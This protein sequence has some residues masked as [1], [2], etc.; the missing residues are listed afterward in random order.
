M[1]QILESVEAEG[2]RSIV[3]PIRFELNRPGLNIIEG[4][5]GVGKTT[6][7]ESI[8]W[9]A[10]GQNLKDTNQDA[11][12]SWEEKRPLSWKGTRVMLNF[13]VNDE[14]YTIA[15]HINYKGKTFGLIGGDTLMVWQ[16][17]D[18]HGYEPKQLWNNLNKDSTQERIN[19]LLGANY[20]TF[21]NSILFGQR[22]VRLVTQDNKDKRALLEQLFDVE[23]VNIAKARADEDIITKKNEYQEILNEQSKISY[24]ILMLDNDM[25]K[26]KQV[27]DNW[28]VKHEGDI[29]LINSS[30]K[31]YENSILNEQNKI[32]LLN[33]GVEYDKAK[34]IKVEEKWG[35]LSDKVDAS[36]IR[37]EEIKKQLTAAQA[38]HRLHSSELSGKTRDKLRIEKQIEDNKKALTTLKDKGICPTCHHELLSDEIKSISAGYSIE[39]L[40]NQISVI[41][42]EITEINKLVLKSIDSETKF[43][44][45]Y[46]IWSDGHSILVNNYNSVTQELDS[47]N[48]IAEKVSEKANR[49]A[50]I[51]DSI[52]ADK[53]RIE[54]LILRLKVL[55]AEKPPVVDFSKTEES[56]RAKNKELASLA[57]M[58]VKKEDEIKVVKWWSEKG[59]GSSGIK[60]FIF[61]AML[62]Q[63]NEGTRKYGK[64]L[65]VSLE[66]AIDLTK[67]S[68]PFTTIC[69]LGDKLNKDYKEFSGGEKQR[70]DIVLI[71][72][73]YDLVSINTNFNVL[74][75]D[76]VSEG[77]DEKGENDVF[78]LIRMKAN[79]GK[80][81]YIITHS[82][83]VDRMHANTIQIEEQD[84]TT[85]IVN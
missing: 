34:H 47:L 46:K 16:G 23:W 40:N 7:I 37:G 15:R 55:E 30:I 80:S 64:R 19:Q 13:K 39:D 25:L 52:K 68:K 32:K 66:F 62:S 11:I 26:D 71:F 45:E 54:E 48:E 49:L 24:Q 36:K 51:D 21:V 9:C 2:Y 1:N 81:V 75:M 12:P 5:N 8:V 58:L 63:L 14:H 44:K 53:V 77:L 28:K 41:D 29:T 42:K 84:L 33:E 35:N 67:A 83:V 20:K 59:F 85:K 74:I 69:S 22:M 3:H 78:D 18:D 57:D 27:A 82:S 17:D 65:G 6:L 60:A 10:Y 50:E 73:M 31:K 61:N 72:A 76:E 4:A 43:E 70:L 79:E 38:D 56:I